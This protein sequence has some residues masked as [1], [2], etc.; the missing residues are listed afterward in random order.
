MLKNPLPQLAILI[1]SVLLNAG[2]ASTETESFSKDSQAKVGKQNTKSAETSK[3][4]D[5][6]SMDKKKKVDA[7][8]QKATKKAPPASWQEQFVQEHSAGTQSEPV[9]NQYWSDVEKVADNILST[10]GNKGSATK[11]QLAR[12]IENGVFKGADAQVAGAL[13]DV[14][15]QVKQP[16]KVSKMLFTPRIS[17]SDVGKTIAQVKAAEARFHAVDDLAYWADN[18]NNL[19][20]FSSDG[21]GAVTYKDVTQALA[22]NDLDTTD[23]SN[24]QSLEQRFHTIAPGGKLGKKEIDVYYNS[25]VHNDPAYKLGKQITQDM[26]GTAE[27]QNNP[28]AQRLFADANP[29]DS[30]KVDNVTQKFAGDC[31]FKAALAAVV[32]TNPESVL[33]M[34]H[35]KSASDLQIKFPGAAD[36]PIQIKPPSSEEIGLYSQG[37]NRG[38]WASA[39]EKGYGELIYQS[40]PD[41]KAIQDKVDADRAASNGFSE[42]ALEALTGH[43]I[44]MFDV[45]EMSANQLRS[46]LATAQRDKMAVVLNTPP[47]S[48]AL[49]TRDGYQ[50]DH[51]FTVLGINAN[52]DVTV[53][54]PRANGQNRPDGT[55]EVSLDKLKANFKQLWVE[56][57]KPLT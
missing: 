39:L 52:G 53:R 36:Q 32:A 1:G 22:R 37:A 24:L 6:Q 10:G 29:I 12:E 5:K 43:K 28:E 25:F 20:R 56:T 51:A 15:D 49:T 45:T 30:I 3:Q 57:N 13:Y 47:G 33:Q 35:A 38:S 42:V 48:Q 23:R 4:S 54:D 18:Q 21:S 14:F 17:E 2:C 16:G 50:L 26:R 41:K 11:E 44:G 55:S 8:E 7:P 9:Y 34:I 40:S 46:T 19:Q 27:V 31:S